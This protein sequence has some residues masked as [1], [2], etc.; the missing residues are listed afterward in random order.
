MSELESGASMR[1]QDQDLIWGVINTQMMVQSEN[2]D[3]IAKNR[4]FR[5]ITTGVGG[6]KGAKRET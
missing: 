2:L 3:K 1:H 6:D 4:S 5:N